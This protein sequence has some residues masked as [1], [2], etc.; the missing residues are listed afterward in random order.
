[1]SQE[2]SEVDEA[3]RLLPT[4]RTILCTAMG[5]EV[6]LRLHSSILRNMRLSEGTAQYGML[7]RGK[8]TDVQLKHRLD[9]DERKT[10]TFA[11]VLKRKGVG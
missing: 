6:C 4:R 1:M 2:C 9:F 3:Y 8:S 10:V 7:E 11:Q 5:H